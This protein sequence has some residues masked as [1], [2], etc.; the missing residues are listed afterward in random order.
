MQQVTRILHIHEHIVDNNQGLR[1]GIQRIEAID[2]H[3]I[4]HTR[5]SAAT[6]S[7]DIATQTLRDERIDTKLRCIVKLVSLGTQYSRGSRLIGSAEGVA[8]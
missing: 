8:I 2:K 1:I 4:S 6:G 3:G 7:A 5:Y